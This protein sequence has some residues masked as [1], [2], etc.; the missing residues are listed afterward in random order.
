MDAAAPPKPDEIEAGTRI[1]VA[2]VGG[3]WCVSCDE[4]GVDLMFLS[5]GR[6]ESQAR[7]LARCLAGLGQD[8]LVEVH[9][10]R[11]A[12]AGV[13]RYVASAA[14]HSFR[15]VVEARHATDPG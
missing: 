15:S 13:T 12:L 6:A 4:C 1:S 9:D 10:R 11:N 3:G 7:T 8:A 5:G 2:P 14:A